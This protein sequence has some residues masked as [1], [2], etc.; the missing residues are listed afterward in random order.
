MR[1]TLDFV[2]T[3]LLLVAAAWELF[4]VD[5]LKSIARSTELSRLHA[6]LDQLHARQFALQQHFDT[7]LHESKRDVSVDFPGVRLQREWNPSPD[8][9]TLQAVEKQHR[10]FREVRVTLFLVGGLLVAAAKLRC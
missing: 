5:A 2:G 3:L 8:V 9:E 10:R 6:K 4:L 7:R 1:T